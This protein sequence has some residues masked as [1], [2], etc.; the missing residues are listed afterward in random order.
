MCIRD[1]HQYRPGNNL[2][3]WLYRILTNTY[4]KIYRKE[5]RQ[6]LESDAAEVQDYQLHRAESHTS[7]GLRSAEMEALD[8]LPDSDV[9][10]ALAQIGEDFR[11]A[12]YL[13]DVEGFS[14]KAVSYTHLDVYKRQVP[15]QQHRSA[16]NGLGPDVAARPA[17]SAAFCAARCP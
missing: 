17:A 10:K 4:I 1:R 6:P 14:Y 16:G 5:Q 8:H 12:V 7:R 13:A 9:T 2:K 11:L 3:A 15:P